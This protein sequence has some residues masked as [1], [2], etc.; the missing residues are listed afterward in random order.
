[1]DDTNEAIEP[2]LPLLGARLIYRTLD[3]SLSYELDEDAVRRYFVTRDKDGA[4]L[5]KIALRRIEHLVPNLVAFHKLLTD[6][7]AIVKQ[8]WVML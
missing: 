7:Q 3:N 6:R 5:E 1:M 4:I 8:T 2:P